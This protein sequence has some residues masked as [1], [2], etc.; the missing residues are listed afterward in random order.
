MVIAWNGKHQL[1]LK[2]VS[3]INIGI[4]IDGTIDSFPILFQHLISGM[5]AHGDHVYIIT[6]V[7][8]PTV[9]DADQSAKAQFLTSVGL[10][11]ESY[12]QLVIVPRTPDKNHAEEKAEY[13]QAHKIDLLIDNN[14]ENCKAAKKYAAVF[15]LYNVKEKQDEGI[16]E[17]RSGEKTCSFCG[18]K[19]N[20]FVQQC[21][22]CGG[23]LSVDTS[24]GLS[25]VTNDRLPLK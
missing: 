17:P 10:P 13:I 20:G 2:E 9:T 3:P 8:A 23:D 18:T 22:H 6:G 7:T 21:P 5:T 16:T 15:L 19:V 11:P 12:Y 1:L 25:E 14:V 4:D 24:D